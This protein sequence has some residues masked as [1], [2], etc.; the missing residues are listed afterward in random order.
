[1][2]PCNRAKVLHLFH[3]MLPIQ[4]YPF[5]KMERQQDMNPTGD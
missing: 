2:T 3:T 5:S 1:M 4:V